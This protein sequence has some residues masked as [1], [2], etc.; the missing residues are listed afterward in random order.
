MERLQSWLVSRKFE[1]FLDHIYKHPPQEKALYN[2][3]EFSAWMQTLRK[4][5]VVDETTCYISEALVIGMA[6]DST[7]DYLQKMRLFDVKLPF[8]SQF[9]AESVLRMT[10]SCYNEDNDEIS[11]KHMMVIPLEI[12]AGH[13]GAPSVGH[14][15]AIFIDF[16]NQI[17][18]RFEPYT[19]VTKNVLDQTAEVRYDY[20]ESIDRFC[21]GALSDLL[22]FLKEFKYLSPTGSCLI[23]LQKKSHPGFCAVWTCLIAQLRLLFSDYTTADIIKLIVAH[24]ESRRKGT[25][26][27]YLDLVKRYA[28]YIQNVKS[29]V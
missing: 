28:S 19:R 9:W 11:G 6:L 29:N 15:N 17:Y 20:N 25:D 3:K 26:D 4:D 10:R 24:V 12:T 23:S 5:P 13:P 27:P 1:R 16:K 18:E 22:P 21:R 14:Q 8:K 2:Q 7:P